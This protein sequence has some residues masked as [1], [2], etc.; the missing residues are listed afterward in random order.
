MEQTKKGA[1][2]NYEYSYLDENMQNLNKTDSSRE[3]FELFKSR[4]PKG[5]K[6]EHSGVISLRPVTNEGQIISYVMET[7]KQVN[8]QWNILHETYKLAYV[9]FKEVLE[10]KDHNTF[11]YWFEDRYGTPF[12]VT[13]FVHAVEKL[14]SLVK[15][16]KDDEDFKALVDKVKS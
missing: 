7:T 6:I 4:L 12:E 15:E 9:D 5:Y 13:S 16:Y 2:Y 1:I 10:V 11:D 14:K 8:T 3:G